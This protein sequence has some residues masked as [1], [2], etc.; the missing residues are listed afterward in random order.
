MTDRRSIT[1]KNRSALDQ[2][3]LVVAGF[4]HLG[5]PAQEGG[6]QQRRNGKDSVH[7]PPIMVGTR[8]QNKQK[9]SEGAREEK[10]QKP[11]VVKA[12][13]GDEAANPR[14]LL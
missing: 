14:S 2:P 7:E 6:Q 12:S 8:P 3:A 10:F 4:H 1:I 5:T 11:L 13:L 9:P